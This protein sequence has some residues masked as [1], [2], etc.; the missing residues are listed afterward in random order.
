M[1]TVIYKELSPIARV[2]PS[3]GNFGLWYWRFVPCLE[4]NLEKPKNMVET[5]Y[6]Q[7][8]NAINNNTG[9]SSYLK[10]VHEEQKLFCQVYENKGYK[11]LCLKA[12]L[13]SPFLTGIGQPHPTEVALLLDRNS[14]LPYI[15][16]SSLKGVVRFAYMMGWLNTFSQD[17]SAIEEKDIGSLLGIFGDQRN[18]GKAIFLDAYPM[19]L[20]S[21]KMDVMSPHYGEYYEDK[22]NPPRSYPKDNMKPVPIKFLVVSSGI[23]FLFRFIVE[24]RFFEETK[25][26]F[27]KALTEEGIGAKTSWGYGRFSVDEGEPKPEE[28]EKSPSLKIDQNSQRKNEG[29][30]HF[31]GK[32]IEGVVV[33][34]K[35]MLDGK[36]QVI[37][38]WKEREE[39]G[40]L[41][42][43]K[44]KAKQYG[45]HQPIRVKIVGM[46][47]DKN[48]P[49]KNFY[50]FELAG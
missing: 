30:T 28:Y 15:P 4:D 1:K 27:V 13:V 12:T 8:H 14:G 35:D 37:V 6:K 46:Q 7:Y 26:A 23:V 34:K 25:S 50:Y 47:P 20:P 9:L 38:K 22:N 21:L 32:I 43:D 39:I 29:N 2:F 3:K 24:E 33:K 31:S 18:I 17:A 10:R 40:K 48:D 16:S 42:L 36:V 44:E 19:T 45:F 11:T 5:I 41:L 49:K